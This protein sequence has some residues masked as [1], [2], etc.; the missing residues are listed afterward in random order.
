MYASSTSAVFADTEAEVT[1]P[2]PHTNVSERMGVLSNHTILRQLRLRWSGHLVRLDNEQ[3]PKRLFYGDVAMGS[4]R[5]GR[6]I[7]QHKDTLKIS[8]RRLQINSTDWKDLALDRPTWRRTMKT[9][10]EIYKASRMAAAKA[11]QGARK[12][13]LRSSRNAN[14]PPPKTVP[15]DI[16]GDNLTCWRPLDQLYQPSSLR[17]PLPR[18][19]RH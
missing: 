4:H 5:Q 12:S 10:G 7:H 19:L 15:A 17:S 8:L 3:L 6:Q 14:A 11:K 9:G 18:L 13:Q 1:G 16:P 2:D